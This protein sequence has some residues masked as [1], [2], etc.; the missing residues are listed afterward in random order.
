MCAGRSDQAG[1]VVGVMY[2]ERVSAKL[3]GKV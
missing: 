2:F 1:K 3:K